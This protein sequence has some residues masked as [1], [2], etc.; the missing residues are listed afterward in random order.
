MFR[1]GALDP[2]RGR[3]Q[4]GRYVAQPEAGKAGRWGLGK[5]GHLPELISIWW[6]KA[7]DMA[8]W[9]ILS[10]NSHSNSSDSI[11]SSRFN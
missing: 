1:Q 4:E 11:C 8:L 7:G 2:S 5:A 3:H 6:N 10:Q 9:Q